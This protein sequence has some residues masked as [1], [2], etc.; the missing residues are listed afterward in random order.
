MKKIFQSVFLFL[1][2]FLSIVSCTND[3]L[4][5][6]DIS[7]IPSGII[8]KEKSISGNFDSVVVNLTIFSN[9]D[10]VFLDSIYDNIGNA[11]VPINTSRFAQRFI[12]FGNNRDLIDYD[13][14]S[15]TTAVVFDDSNRISWVYE[16]Y[17]VNRNY[18]FQES[19]EIGFNYDNQNRLQSL[20]SYG[21]RTNSGC[22]A[23]M[24]FSHGNFYSSSSGN[25]SLVLTI[26]GPSCGVCPYCVDTVIVTFL[27]TPNNTKLA[28]LSFPSMVSS[29][30]PSS[31]DYMLLMQY[32]PFPKLNGKLID[33]IYYSNGNLRYT[34]SYTFDG[35]GRVKTAKTAKHYVY[36]TL[37]EE[38][39]EFNY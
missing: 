27:N 4:R 25:D 38:L 24:L 2:A 21:L 13:G 26:E 36:N 23:F 29:S 22:F 32:L 16:R 33:K 14:D 17:A 10:S 18:Q 20:P 8:V 5:P 12:Y 6:T 11:G 1:I 9:N 37:K 28:T 19:H 15:V 7:N 3:P 39:I 35:E 31:N 30:Y 34:N